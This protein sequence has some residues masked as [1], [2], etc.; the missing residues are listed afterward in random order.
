MDLLLANS[1]A[2][3][4]AITEDLGAKE[5]TPLLEDELLA[6]YDDLWR[7]LLRYAVSFGLPVQDGED[8]IQETFLALFRHLQS[9]RPRQ[10]LRSWVFRVTH[11]QALKRR[12]Q[13]KSEIWL[14]EAEE[15]PLV[16]CDPAPGPEGSLLFRERQDRL[17]RVVQA[18]STNDQACLRLR[19]EGLRYREIAEIVGISLGSVSNSLSRSLER[20]ER[21]DRR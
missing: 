14:A 3:L 16:D 13:Q 18:L 12:M 19:A 5:A 11:N 2:E 1:V 20:L 15:R 6:M 10:N 21:M 4:S 7:P 17:R 9:G 8:V